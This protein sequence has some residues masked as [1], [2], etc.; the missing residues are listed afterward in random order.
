MT[1]SSTS[2]R[3]G[4]YVGNGSTTEFAWTFKCLDAATMKV[5]QT[6]G[7][8][9]TEVTTGITKN[10]IPGTSGTVVF[11]TPPATGTLITI[12][13]ESDFLQSS[14]YASEGRVT[15]EQVEDDLD[16]AMMAVQDL[17]ELQE[18]SLRV[19]VAAL[20]DPV[21]PVPAPGQVI[22][23]NGAGNALINIGAISTDDTPVT[24][25]VDNAVLRWNSDLGGIQDGVVTISDTGEVAGVLSLNGTAPTAAG[26]ALFGAADAAAQRTSLGVVIGTH[27]Q[28]YNV[29]LAALASI[30]IDAGDILYGDGASSLTA[31]PKGTAGQIIRMN[32][33]A[34]APEWASLST[35]KAWVNF[36]GTGTVAI[37]GSFNVASVTD[38]GTGDYTINFTDPMPDANYAA[39]GLASQNSGAFGVMIVSQAAGSV[40]I[41]TRNTASNALTD[42]STICVVVFA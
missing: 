37:R 30:A 2:N 35:A 29:N 32:S 20:I 4:P 17:L 38:N 12:I 14:D 27:V 41:E 9:T 6:I 5:Y 21:L 28:A 39:V 10:G 23:W 19:D 25:A 1:V 16:R 26:L 13:R 34:T 31:L 36:N 15:P 33:G 3:N 22:G 18:R 24:A 7:G 40:R 8:V 11:T 42:L